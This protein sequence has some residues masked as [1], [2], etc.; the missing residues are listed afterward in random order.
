M[1]K[2]ENKRIGFLYLGIVPVNI[3]ALVLLILGIP[4]SAQEN[5]S[6]RDT[7]FVPLIV[8]MDV[9][10]EFFLIETL[11]GYI[12]HQQTFTVGRDSFNH[13]LTTMKN[14][15]NP[16]LQQ[17]IDGAD[18][19]YQRV[20]R[21]YPWKKNLALLIQFLFGDEFP[22]LYMVGSPGDEATIIRLHP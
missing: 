14:S 19:N 18:W 17:V 12:G 5:K 4:I 9:D 1:A 21:Y 6:N 2:T 10:Q 13:M 20:D 22:D 15:N 8:R 16:F 11:G 3:I 7:L